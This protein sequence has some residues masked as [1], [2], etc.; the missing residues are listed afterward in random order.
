L[1]GALK[2]SIGAGELAVAA[3]A[4]GTSFGTFSPIG[5]LLTVHGSDQLTTGARM[6]YTGE[7][8]DTL[9]AQG[10]Q[11]TG[12]SGNTSRALDEGY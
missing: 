8:R 9:V 7:H 11:M 10:L 4:T 5:V 1:H 6:L 12:L 2:V 3:F